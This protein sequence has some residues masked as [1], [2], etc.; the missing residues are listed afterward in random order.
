M[1]TAC[2]VMYAT[3][4]EI[5]VVGMVKGD[6]H[7]TRELVYRDKCGGGFREIPLKE[8]GIL[9]KYIGTIQEEVHRFA[10]EYHRSVRDKKAFVSVLDEIKG[11]GQVR[12]R[13]LLQ[14]FG[15]VERIKAASADELMEVPGMN[16]TSAE[17]VW[18]YFHPD[19]AK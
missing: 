1:T 7:R 12:R 19:S 15:S 2:C 8:K 9:F 3:G 10:I 17:S 4:F 11:I 18:K 6:N 16:R 14:H 5:P 13:A